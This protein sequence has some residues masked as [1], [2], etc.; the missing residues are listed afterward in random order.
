VTAAVSV[1]AAV[2]AIWWTVRVGH[3]GAQA[4]W[5]GIVQSTNK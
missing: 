5:Q 2:L 1:A 3:S 4:V